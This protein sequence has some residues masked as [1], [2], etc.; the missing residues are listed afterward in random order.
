MND[1]LQMTVLLRP[2]TRLGLSNIYETTYKNEFK[3]FSIF[4]ETLLLKGL[5]ILVEAPEEVV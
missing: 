1:K 5:G 2:K 4:I 3:S